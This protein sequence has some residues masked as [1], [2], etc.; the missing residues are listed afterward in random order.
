MPLEDG[1]NSGQSKSNNTNDKSSPTMKKSGRVCNDA[2]I[3]AML[4]LRQGSQENKIDEFLN[5]LVQD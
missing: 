1:S 4:K 2:M 3:K 5:K